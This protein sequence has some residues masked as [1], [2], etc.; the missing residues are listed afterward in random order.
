[1]F[2][3]WIVMEVRNI[4]HGMIYF[5]LNVLF[6]SFDPAPRVTLDSER[7]L[8]FEELSSIWSK[9]EHEITKEKRCTDAVF[10]LFD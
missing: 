6:I 4:V 2:L 3:E 1:M 8:T 7:L 9:E 10:F 5:F